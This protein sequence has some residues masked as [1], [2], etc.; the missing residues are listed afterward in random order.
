[1]DW[2]DWFSNVNWGAVGAISS[3]VA[4]IIALLTVKISIT[5][6]KQAEESQQYSVQPWFHVT[7]ISRMGGNA[8]NKLIIFN[9][10]SPHI[11][12]NEVV[13]CIDSK[14][15]CTKLEF[16]YLKK[17]NKFIETGKCF[18]I[19]IPYNEEWFDKEGVLKINFT[20]LYNK[21]MVSISPKMKFNTRVS[22]GTVQSII[23]EG[24][25]Y[26]PFINKIEM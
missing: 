1:M 11:R 22:S 9:D 19:E 14:R 17:D 20:N 26:I 13:L 8:P 6:S 5:N 23:S 2:L 18:G 4:S 16:K 3:A 21:N 24:F 10:A 15:E 7:S 12:I 25:L